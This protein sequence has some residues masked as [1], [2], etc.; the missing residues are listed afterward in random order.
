MKTNKVEKKVVKKTRKAWIRIINGDVIYSLPNLDG[1]EFQ[2][3]IYD[4]KNG[5]RFRV[6]CTIT[7]QLPQE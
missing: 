5:D 6:P 3:Q 2:Y 4:T 7:Y 1:K